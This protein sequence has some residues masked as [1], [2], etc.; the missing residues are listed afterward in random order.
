MGNS[1]SYKK[2]VTVTDNCSEGLIFTVDN[3]AVN[4]SV[5]GTYPITY[6]AKDAAGNET[7]ASA[8]V[9]VMWRMC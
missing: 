2:N 6:I 3:S 1:I 5:A 8:N 4:L 9:T 7:I